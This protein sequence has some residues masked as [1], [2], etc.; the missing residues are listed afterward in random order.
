MGKARATSFPINCDVTHVCGCCPTYASHVMRAHDPHVAR[1]T[2]V[3]GKRSGR[4]SGRGKN[5][6]QLPAHRSGPGPTTCCAYVWP[7]PG[8][9]FRCTKVGALLLTPLLVHGQSEPPATATHR[10]GRKGKPERSRSHKENKA[11]TRTRATKI[12]WT[13]QVSPARILAGAAL[14]APAR[15]LPEELAPTSRASHLQA[16]QR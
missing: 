12:R 10:H 1:S 13:E 5:P 9:S 15:P 4:N 11:T 3:V 6:P 7:R 14:A 8:G 16:H 2:W